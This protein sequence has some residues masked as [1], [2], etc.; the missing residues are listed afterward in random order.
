MNKS[1]YDDL[2]SIVMQVCVCVCVFLLLSVSA[3]L[4]VF[5]TASLVCIFMHVI[6]T[7]PLVIICAGKTV[8]SVCVG[9]HACVGIPCIALL[10]PCQIAIVK[11]E[12]R[13]TIVAEFCRELGW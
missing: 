1:E 7:Y 9:V 4:A 13:I 3:Q 11:R 8:L 10:H 2:T 5:T 12:E 6:A